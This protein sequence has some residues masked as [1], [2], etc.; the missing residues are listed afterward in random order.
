MDCSLPGFSVHGILQARIL[1]WVALF[2]RIFLTRDWNCVSYLLHVLY[3]SHHLGSPGYIY[4]HKI[5]MYIHIHTHTNTHTSVYQEIYHKKLA[6]AV[7]KAG[8]TTLKSVDYPIRD[9]S[10]NSYAQA[11]AAVHRQNFVFL[12]ETSVLPLGSFNRLGWPTQM[13]E[14]NLLYLKSTDCRG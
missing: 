9:K 10:R 4:T 14:G 5:Y 12:R 8:E 6:F 7:M 3:Q 2:Q 13:I 11:K 1:E